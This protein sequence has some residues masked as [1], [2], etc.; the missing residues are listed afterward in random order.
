MTNRRTMCIWGVVFGWLVLVVACYTTS[1][2]NRRATGAPPSG[3]SSAPVAPPG[4]G[5]RLQR[6]YPIEQGIEGSASLRIRVLPSG[7]VELVSVLKETNEAFSN[8]CEAMLRDTIWEPARNLSGRSVAAEITY[9]CGF[10]ET[11]YCWFCARNETP[12]L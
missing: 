5:T 7:R 8:A 9:T 4:L 10:D 6:F 12:G 1:S 3:L 11:K 2:S